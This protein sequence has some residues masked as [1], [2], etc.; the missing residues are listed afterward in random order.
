MAP[1]KVIGAAYG[2]TGT[3]SLRYALDILGY[4]THHM[5]CFFTDP[6]LDC[7]G[8]YNA[9]H[10]REEAD[11]DKLLADYDALTDFSA[12]TFYYDL[13][14][15]YP[16]AKVIL[17]VRPVDSWYTSVKNTI[18]RTIE[19]LPDPEEG[20]KQFDIL[21]LCK[22]VC[23]DGKLFNPESFLKEEEIKQMYRDHI[24]EVKKNIPE[25]Q[26][27]VVE[28]GEGWERMCKFLGKDVPDVPYPKSNST[29]QFIDYFLSQNRPVDIIPLLT[30]S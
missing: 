21:R 13:Y 22:T 26:L 5:K 2:R 4:N 16:D 29:A 10:N 30:K 6:N 1:I 28:L 12:A 7:D 9:C 14:K 18:F 25:D 20:S 24:E 19:E 3:E 15:K 17:S 23:L 11:W 8:F 27:L